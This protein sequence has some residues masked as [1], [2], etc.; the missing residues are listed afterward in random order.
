MNPWKGGERE[1]FRALARALKAQR[2]SLDDVSD[3]IDALKV[4]A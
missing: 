1:Q 3:L 4:M 2:D